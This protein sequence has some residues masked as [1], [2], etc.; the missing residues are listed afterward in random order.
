MLV[1]DQ[2]YYQMD[3]RLEDNAIVED[4]RDNPTFQ[5]SYMSGFGVNLTAGEHILKM[6]GVPTLPKTFHFRNIYLVKTGKYQPNQSVPSIPD[7]PLFPEDVEKPEEDIEKDPI[8]PGDLP[9]SVKMP[10]Q[11]DNNQDGIAD[12]FTFSSA[13]PAQFTSE[14]AIKID[15]SKY[16]ADSIGVRSLFVANIEHYYL[17]F[18]TEKDDPEKIALN[19]NMFISWEFEVPETGYYDFCFQLRMKDGTNRGNMM[20]IDGVELYKMDFQFLNGSQIEV[21]DDPLIMNSYMTGF[22]AELTAGKHILTMKGVPTIFKAFHFRAIYLV[23][24][25]EF[26]SGYDPII[27]F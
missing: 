26:G 17:D 3:Y 22:G 11:F 4:M 25:G 6:K 24:T 1:D 16:T 20:L 18:Y 2:V 21:M 13:I 27:P 9:N 15:A 23:K 19:S 14:Q 8:E 7:Y 10:S 12:T 5:T